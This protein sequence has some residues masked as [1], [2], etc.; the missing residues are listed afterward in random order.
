[1][2]YG[3]SG[4][5]IGRCKLFNTF[6][7]LFSIYEVEL[8]YLKKREHIT[9]QNTIL[10]P[11]VQ[12]SRKAE[13]KHLL[14]DAST[15][16]QSVLENFLCSI[17]FSKRKS[18]LVLLT[19]LQISKMDVRSHCHDAPVV[20]QPSVEHDLVTIVKVMNFTEWSV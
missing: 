8:D 10:V 15:L 19:Q 20:Q 12:S 6:D 11:L 5:D 1:M 18:P 16:R 2:K 3:L 13:Y 7:Y 4:E 17:S 9:S 14:P